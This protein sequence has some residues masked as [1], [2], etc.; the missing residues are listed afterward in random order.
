MVGLK[1]QVIL[2]LTSLLPDVEALSCSILLLPNGSDLDRSSP[3]QDVRCLQGSRAEE[4]K[5][6]LV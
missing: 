6:Q 3:K 5:R 1:E 2:S 4:G